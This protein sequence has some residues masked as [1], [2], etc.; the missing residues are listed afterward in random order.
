M[1][2]DCDAREATMKENQDKSKEVKMEETRTC[3]YNSRGICRCS[4]SPKCAEECNDSTVTTCEYFK[5]T[6]N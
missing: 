1:K 3:L 2:T 5:G 6:E 4:R